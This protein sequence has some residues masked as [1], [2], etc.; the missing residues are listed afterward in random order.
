[1]ND[2]DI[3]DLFWAR[4]ESAI[5]E[6]SRK[7]DKLARSVAM[8]ILRDRQ[9]AEECM[10]D[11]YLGMWNSLP[12]HRPAVLPAFFTALT[13]NNA[14]KRVRYKTAEKRTVLMTELT[15][16]T[17]S[18]PSPEE[19]IDGAAFVISGYLREMDKTSRV[20]FMRRYY[21]GE[22]VR[23]AAEAVG[24]SENAASVRLSRIRK[25][26]KKRLEKEGITV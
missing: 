15:D 12:P 17:G 8:N 18:T 16:L 4:S 1:V 21:L 26:L 3:I 2:T 25:R 5:E 22:S 14:L 6:L 7:Y 11:S 19:E 20:L 9:D 24:L 13:R 10:N 23:E